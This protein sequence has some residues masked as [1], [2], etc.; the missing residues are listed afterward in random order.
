MYR[1]RRYD[2]AEVR[3]ILARAA[4]RGDAA[5]D[6]PP[7]T[8]EE[9]EALGAELGLSR[10][11]VRA[12]ATGPTPA[13][14][15]AARSAAD[16][17]F[18]GPRRIQHETVIP[19][20]FDASRHEA[21]VDLVRTRVGEIG[22][23]ETLGDTLTWYAGGPQGRMLTVSVKPVAGGTR[24][25]IDDRLGGVAGGLFGGLGGGGGGGL[26]GG[27]GPLLTLVFHLPLWTVG[28]FV[29]GS[30]V[31]ALALARAIFA[32]IARKRA[33]EDGELLSALVVELEGGQGAPRIAAPTRVA[34]APSAAAESTG[35][36]EDAEDGDDSTSAASSPARRG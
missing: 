4:G 6:A 12:A 21:V 29:V 33:R 15:L 17:F 26:G 2:A 23:A 8:L 11:A 10:E 27:L 3:A 35:S 19:A 7:R 28:A 24:I 36:A 16:V 5:T 31:L 1:D 20:A 9:I 18:G 14:P 34:T 13:P 32:S 30:I 25:R 22:R